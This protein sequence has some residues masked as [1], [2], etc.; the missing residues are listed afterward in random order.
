MRKSTMSKLIEAPVQVKLWNG[1]FNVATC[2]VELSNAT[3]E[4]K[5]KVTHPHLQ[6]QCGDKN[7]VELC[8]WVGCNGH[9]LEIPEGLND[10]V[11]QMKNMATMSD[12][13][14][15]EI[16]R[17]NKIDFLNSMKELGISN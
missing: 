4:L 6:W 2:K 3:Y 1:C 8:K 15:K 9:F 10:K 16:S 13:E 7:S 5:V 12:E 17:M 11:A 14:A